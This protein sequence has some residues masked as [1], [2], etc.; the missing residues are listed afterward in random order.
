MY[1]LTVQAEFSAA[2]AIT[3]GGRREPI[4]GHN[5]RVRVQIQGPQLDDEGLLCDFHLVESQLQEIVNP[6]D[7]RTLN[8][9]PPF[10]R[11]NPTAER[12]AQH[13]AER[14]SESLADRLPAEA[15]VAQV[16]VTEAPGCAAAF[17]P[18]SDV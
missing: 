12:V 8:E 4:H 17:R 3:I 13:I 9:T 1:E 18:H 16:S 15:R 14:L 10:D 7:N 5:W 2:H 11:L 6:F